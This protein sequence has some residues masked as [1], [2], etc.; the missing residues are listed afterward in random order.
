MDADNDSGGAIGAGLFVGT[1]G[2]FQTGGPAAVFLGF[3]IIG[4]NM[5]VIMVIEDD[6]SNSKQ[7]PHDASSC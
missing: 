5:Y 1:G 4:L 2:A 7:L 3:I 6:H